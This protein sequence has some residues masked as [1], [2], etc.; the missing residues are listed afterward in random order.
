MTCLNLLN[1]KT[2]KLRM[3]W[4]GIWDLTC[5]KS[6]LR[7]IHTLIRMCS[8]YNGPLC[9]FRCSMALFN[10][11]LFHLKAQTLQRERE[12]WWISIFSAFA[13]GWFKTFLFYLSNTSCVPV[14]SAG[15]FPLFVYSAER[16][17]NNIECNL[18]SLLKGLLFI[19]L[20]GVETP[21]VC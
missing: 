10:N 20:L 12:E 7:I 14:V 2:F 18:K 15:S 1:L 9:F 5:K 13:P 17:L 16:C 8:D 4:D 6:P 11:C 21:C 19:Y 3:Q